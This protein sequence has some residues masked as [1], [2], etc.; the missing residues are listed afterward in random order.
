CSWGPRAFFKAAA[1]RR[2]R[3]S[4][5]SWSPTALRS[6][7]KESWMKETSLPQAASRHRSTWGC[8]WWRDWQAPMRA[9]ALLLRWIIHTSHEAL[10]HSGVA[11][12][13]HGADR[14]AGKE[15]GK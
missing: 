12:R 13:A 2:T 10:H 1:Q 7:A 4:T 5:R 6:S 11:V 3:T 9:G 14:G 15:A 8:T